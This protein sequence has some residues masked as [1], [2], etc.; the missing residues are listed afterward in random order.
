MPTIQNPSMSLQP[1]AAG[2]KLTVTYTAEV[3]AIEAFLMQNGL[4]VEERVQ[5]FGIDGAQI[6][7]TAIWTS[8]PEPLVL[9]VGSTSVA[10]TREVTLPRA[11]LQ[12]DANEPIYVYLPARPGDPWWL[13]QQV[14][15]GYRPD[16]D[17]LL[18]RVDLSY[19]GF[20]SATAADTP[21]VVLR[22]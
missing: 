19:A 3:S 6:G 4:V 8:T 2:V 10:R 11:S 12:E 15:I 18:A 16:D 21:V 7:P 14:L 1:L 9:P 22:G 5:L 13:R 20:P 17:E